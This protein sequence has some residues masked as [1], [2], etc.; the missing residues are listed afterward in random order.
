MA[1]QIDSENQLAKF[2]IGDNFKRLSKFREAVNYYSDILYDSNGKGRIRII[3]TDYNGE[4]S[5]FDVRFEEVFYERGL[6]LYELKSLDTAFGDFN[7][8]IKNNYMVRES[9]YMLGAI[10]ES[11]GMNKEACFEYTFAY[12][13]G[14]PYAH[15]GIAATCE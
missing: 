3:A 10:Y 11:Y 12:N 5:G 9:R 1:L 13:L 2:N 7:Q 8:C 14:D 6:A 4:V 15:E